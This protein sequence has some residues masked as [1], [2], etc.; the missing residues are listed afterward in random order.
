MALFKVPLMDD[1][2]LTSFTSRLAHANARSAREFCVDF[3]FSW[4]RVISGSDDAITRVAELSGIDHQR[5]DAAAVKQCG[6]KTVW[7]AGEETPFMF[8]M[9]GVI[10]F[11][12]CCF[13]ADEERRDLRPGTRKYMRKMWASRFIRTCPVHGQALVSAG[14]HGQ[15]NYIH[16]LCWSLE[17]L[18]RDVSIAAKNTVPQEFTAFEEYVHARLRGNKGESNFLNDL[19]LFVAGDI[20]ELA[21]LVSIHG[22]RV[23]IHDKTERQRW[24]AS[25]RGFDILKSGLPGLHGFLDGL[26][27]QCANKRATVG[28]NQLFGKFHEILANRKVDAAYEPVKEAARSYAFNSLSLTDGTMLFGKRGNAAF[29]S[30]SSLERKHGLSE[31]IMR[32]YFKT[33]GA[34]ITMPGTDVKAVPAGEVEG[35]VAKMRDLIRSGE[36]AKTLGVTEAAFSLLVSGGLVQTEVARDPTVKF[37]ARF[38]RKALMDFSS[39]LVGRATTKD[40]TGLMPIKAVGKSLLTTLVSILRLILDGRIK[41]IGLDP[42]G[43]GIT[44]LMLDRSEVAA[45]LLEATPPKDLR[46]F[47][48]SD[49]ALGLMANTNSIY[50]FFKTGYIET[51][52]RPHAITGQR[53]RLATME[54]MRSFWEKHVTLSECCHRS[55]RHHASVRRALENAGI[56]GSFPKG[57]VREQFYPRTQA[58]TALGL[59]VPDWDDFAY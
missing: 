13:A 17:Y 21:G 32:K 48:A 38:S 52:T 46:Y 49:L 22:R 43:M 8:Y 15:P 26:A 55:K 57:V 42:A 18:R 1:E 47:T 25:A 59:T 54:T 34:D 12:P 37:S 35:L 58:M 45:L 7:V 51:I 11:C 30:F 19:P 3:D 36:A 23:S 2:S 56:E 50:Y 27:A 31:P 24:E 28:G 33:I 9:R 41:T 14:T 53:Q 39:G 16:D 4:R 40:L 5:L 6:E 10:K 29:V 20:C 44:S